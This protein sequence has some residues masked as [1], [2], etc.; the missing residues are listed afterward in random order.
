MRDKDYVNPTENGILSWRRITSCEIDSDTGLEN[1]KLR[2]HKVSKRRCACIER[3]V[4]WVGTKIREPPSFHG[5]NDLETFLAQY[6]DAFL[7]NQILLAL[8]IA[9]K[10][11]PI[12]WW[13]IHKDTI[14]E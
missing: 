10:A 7:E 3:I 5:I 14:I 8:D 12:R 11:T 6:E 2:P 13:S 4:R 1:W 9:L